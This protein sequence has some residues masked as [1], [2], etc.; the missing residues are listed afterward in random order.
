M[1]NYDYQPQLKSFGYYFKV[2]FVEQSV[3]SREIP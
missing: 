1:Q 2:V 3:I